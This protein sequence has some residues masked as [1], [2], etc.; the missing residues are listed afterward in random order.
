MILSAAIVGASEKHFVQEAQFS[1]SVCSVE[2]LRRG[3]GKSPHAQKAL[4]S[5]AECVPTDRNV[6]MGLPTIYH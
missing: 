2:K 4:F 3:N 6:R 5:S 1:V